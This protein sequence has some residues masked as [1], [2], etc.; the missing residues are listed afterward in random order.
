MPNYKGTPKKDNIVTIVTT[1]NKE[2]VTY[3]FKPE[4]EIQA[5]AN[6]RT[7]KKTLL[8][9]PEFLYSALLDTILNEIEDL[10]SC[11]FISVYKDTPNLTA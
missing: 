7:G 8:I 11:A 9:G 1:D 10:D 2:T 6:E 3:T 4:P 5:K